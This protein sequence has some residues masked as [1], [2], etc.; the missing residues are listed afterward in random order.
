VPPPGDARAPSYAGIIIAKQA[1]KKMK[2]KK[3]GSNSL[4][5][6]RVTGWFLPVLLLFPNDWPVPP[7][8]F[9]GIDSGSMAH[10]E[11]TSMGDESS[12]SCF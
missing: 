2:K 3:I 10:N 12:P 9:S 11:V 6:K 8:S 7:Y 5:Y 4:G 1:R